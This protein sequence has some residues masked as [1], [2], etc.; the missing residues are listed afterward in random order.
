MLAHAAG[1]ENSRI[2]LLHYIS[3]HALQQKWD[4]AHGKQIINDEWGKTILIVS[5]L[6]AIIDSIRSIPIHLFAAGRVD[7]HFFPF[8]W[9]WQKCRVSALDRVRKHNYLHEEPGF[10]WALHLTS[11]TRRGAGV[12]HVKVYTFCRSSH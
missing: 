3:D 10:Q 11:K 4:R 7:T 12:N 9:K 2:L 6:K 1:I 8:L 5:D